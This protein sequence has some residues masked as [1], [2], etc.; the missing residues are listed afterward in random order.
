M[1]FFSKKKLEERTGPI[2][3][4]LLIRKVSGLS[5]Q[6]LVE[7]TLP[8]MR[9]MDRDTPNSSQD[10]RRV[11]IEKQDTTSTNI[12]PTRLAL[13]GTIGNKLRITVQPAH[14]LYSCE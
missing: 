13:P 2:H 9:T 5:P 7:A 6:R 10:P 12:C 1:L 11:R 8:W 14:K 3:V 4:Q